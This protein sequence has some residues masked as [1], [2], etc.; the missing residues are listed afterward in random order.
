MSVSL[1]T[2]HIS[3]EFTFFGCWTLLAKTN[4]P[5]TISPLHFHELSIHSLK[6]QLCNHFHRHKTITTLAAPCT[7]CDPVYVSSFDDC[8]DGSD[9]TPSHLSDWYILSCK[10]A[11]RL[12]LGS[13]HWPIQFNGTYTLPGFT[14]CLGVRA[15]VRILMVP[16]T[17][18][19]RSIAEVSKGRWRM[20]SRPE[21]QCRHTLSSGKRF[22]ILTTSH[23][24]CFYQKSDTRVISSDI[25]LSSE[26]VVRGAKLK[27]SHF[28]SFYFRR[29]R[30]MVRLT[31]FVRVKGSDER[32]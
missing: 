18:E 30:I 23:T 25:T 31:L 7:H 2:E 15:S 13:R 26:R 10:K 32:K 17:C 19:E 28:P 22:L 3:C 8:K 21:V 24:K 14:V 16:I 27:L 9:D 11:S 1:G 12:V 20:L 6:C 5:Y 4:T 29:V